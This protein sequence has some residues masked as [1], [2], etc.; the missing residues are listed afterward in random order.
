MAREGLPFLL[1]AA[2]LTGICWLGTAYYAGLMYA[3]VFFGVLSAF[4]VFFFRDPSRV[5]PSDPGAILAAGDGRVVAIEPVGEEEYLNGPGTRIS[6]FL[7][8]FNVH[9][10][11]APMAGT[12]DFVAWHRA[13]FHAAYKTEAS[14]DN[15]Q[16]IIGISNGAARLIVKQI[17]GVV[18]RR[19]ACYLTAGDKV[20][21]GERFGLIRFGSRVDHILPVETEILVEVGDR[22]RAGETIIGISQSRAA[23]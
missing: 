7:S 16:S 17:V 11:R 8:V 3:A 21:L 23:T 5:P 18:A 13:G 10:N 1:V 19:I 2:A 20:R 4:V 9:V 22:V 12:V 14:E 6:V 15:T